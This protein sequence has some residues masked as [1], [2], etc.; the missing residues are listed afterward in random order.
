M[1]TALEE[2]KDTPPPPPP[3]P[4]LRQGVV[5]TVK[6]V[7]DND[8]TAVIAYVS[9]LFSQEEDIRAVAKAGMVV[10]TEAGLV[11]RLRG[12]FGKLGKCKVEFAGGDGGSAVQ[13]GDR[14]SV[15][16]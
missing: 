12:P 16:R 5:D 11:G 14:V 8:E 7:V 3:P 10:R 15:P 2:G 4:P 13:A 6:E 1:G 9:G